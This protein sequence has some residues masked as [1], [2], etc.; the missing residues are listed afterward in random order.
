LAILIIELAQNIIQPAF[1]LIELAQNIIQPAFYLIE[2]A[3]NII[4]PAF[5]APQAG[6]WHQVRVSGT[7]SRCLA[8]SAGGTK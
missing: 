4:Q 2:L 5:L 8:P 7:T 6:V 3:Q 1:Y